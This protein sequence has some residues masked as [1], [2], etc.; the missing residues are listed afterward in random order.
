MQ[1]ASLISRALKEQPPSAPAV[2]PPHPRSTAF[3]LALLAL[4]PCLSIYLLVF[5]GPFI[6]APVYLSVRLCL[7]KIPSLCISMWHTQLIFLHPYHKKTDKK[8]NIF[9]Y[10]FSL[11]KKTTK[12]MAPAKPSEIHKQATSFVLLLLRLPSS[13]SAIHLHEAYTLPHTRL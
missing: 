8:R 3:V 4:P 6:S 7:Q 12:L 9:S 11:Q 1:S 2:R 13:L 10:Q 5:A